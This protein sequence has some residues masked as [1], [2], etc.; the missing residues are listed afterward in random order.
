M[1]RD[2]NAGRSHSIKIDNSSSERMEEFEYLWKPLTN[3]KFSLGKNKNQIEV[4]ECFLSFGTESF[5]LEFA[6]QK[7]KD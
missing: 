5:V 4:R 6:I 7:F 2:Q 1:S 3:K